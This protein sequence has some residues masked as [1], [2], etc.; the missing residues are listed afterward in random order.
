MEG[1]RYDKALDCA[2]RF[3]AWVRRSFF[4]S[5][6][7]AVRNFLS[8]LPVLF[9]VAAVLPAGS[10]ASYG[11]EVISDGPV[12]YW[13]LG[14]AT[15]VT[16]SDE[17]GNGH[18]G[19]YSGSPTLGVDGLIND[20]PDTA[21]AFDGLDDR[22]SVANHTD[23]NTN[24]VPYE[25]KTVELWFKTG[26]DISTR[27]VIYEQGGSVRGLNI[28]LD[29]GLVYINGWN[30]IN[31]DGGAT[32]PWGPAYVS[33]A[34]APATRYYV[35]LVMEHSTG[36]VEGFLNGASMGA[37]SGVGKLYVH[38]GDINIARNGNT[39]FHDGAGNSVGEYF[40]GTVDELAVYNIALSGARTLAHYQAGL[41]RPEFSS[42]YADV[43]VNAGSAI[44]EQTP[45][46][47]GGES[48]YSYSV[49]PAL[50]SGVTVDPVTGK[51]SGTPA[52]G[53]PA[54]SYTV[55]VSD[56]NGMSDTATFEMAVLA[57][58]SSSQKSSGPNP[59]DEAVTPPT[60]SAE[61]GGPGPVLSH[62]ALL[63]RGRR[64]SDRSGRRVAK[65]KVGAKRGRLKRLTSSSY[66]RY[67][68]S[69][70]SQVRIVVWRRNGGRK[71]G[72]VCVPRS[73]LKEGPLKLPICVRSVKMRVIY[74]QGLE[75]VNRVKFTGHIGPYMMRHGG[76]H[77]TIEAVDSEGKR[78]NREKV[79]FA[80]E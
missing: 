77:A 26:T 48:P 73:L 62:L 61:D 60:K 76:Y 53:S 30:L 59:V 39:Y 42:G 69:K 49:A 31:D 18:L 15:G 6:S 9:L 79:K 71:Y 33:S 19:T 57:P 43:S 74:R 22:I 36:R 13:R 72:N 34:V 12:A 55:T 66:F 44:A 50:P 47:G 1:R 16:A 46:V 20:D 29:G 65:R 23:I 10:L 17:S 41:S 2:R 27:Q 28:Y 37:A 63:R 21:V 32:T 52:T 24:P 58:D 68:L 56:V 75:G 5:P 7:P 40:S 67:H 38:S 78:S 35:V 11:S 64:H 25:S 14:E 51:L 8:L 70:K 54:T 80:I 4:L 45:T 3:R